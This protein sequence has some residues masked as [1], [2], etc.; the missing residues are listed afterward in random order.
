AAGNQP[1]VSIYLIRDYYFFPFADYILYSDGYV[2][3]S[4]W[5]QQPLSSGMWNCWSY[6]GATQT[7]T[8]SCGTTINATLYVYGNATISANVGFSASPWI[9]S[10]V[11][12]KSI[13]VLSTN[14]TAR[15]PTVADGTL[16]HSGTQNI[17]FLARRDIKIT[18]QPGQNLTGIIAAREQVGI[19]GNPSIN[20]YVLAADAGTTSTLV[21]SNSISGALN[22]TYNGDKGNPYLGNV[23]VVT[24]QPG[25]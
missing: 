14:I 19:S 9:T 16:Y 6:N 5:H 23:Q 24:W 8:L 3:D 18:G 11:S 2:Y 12:T 7:W 20:G 21:T 25:P 22:L 15:P 10:I 4:S 17:L 1:T 13:Q